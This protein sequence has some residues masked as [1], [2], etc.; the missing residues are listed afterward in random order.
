MAIPEGEAARRAQRDALLQQFGKMMDRWK[1]SQRRVGGI[2]VQHLNSIGAVPVER[3]DVPEHHRLPTFD[4]P[5]TKENPAMRVSVRGGMFCVGEHDFY[6]GDLGE[7]DPAE[8]RDVFALSLDFLRQRRDIQT[9][10]L[11]PGE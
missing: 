11:P 5:A 2:L 7:S 9:R 1:F 4:L 8:I 10:N 3:R 6:T